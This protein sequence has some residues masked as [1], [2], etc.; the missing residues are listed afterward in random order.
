MEHLYKKTD[1]QVLSKE[2]YRH[3]VNDQSKI[4]GYKTHLQEGVTGRHTDRRTN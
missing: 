4:T 3:I 2:M 1:P